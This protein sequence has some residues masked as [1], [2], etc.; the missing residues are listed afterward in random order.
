V[1]KYILLKLNRWKN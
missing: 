1:V